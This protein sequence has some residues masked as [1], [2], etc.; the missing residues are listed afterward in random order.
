MVH[1]TPTSKIENAPPILENSIGGCV[2]GLASVSCDEVTTSEI[3]L[4]QS[5][6]LQEEEE[7]EAK[8]WCALLGQCN[9]GGTNRNL[10]RQSVLARRHE[11]ALH[12]HS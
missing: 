8:S 6:H 2:H 9:D 11:L 12:I 5:V 7:E 3:A 1:F 10:D 4:H